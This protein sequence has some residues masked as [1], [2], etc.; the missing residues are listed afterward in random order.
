[1]SLSFRRSQL[2]CRLCGAGCYPAVPMASVPPGE[3]PAYSLRYGAPGPDSAE[4]IKRKSNKLFDFSA[5][6]E[7][8]SEHWAFV[9]STQT[10]LN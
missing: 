10:N 7:K 4:P 8:L 9:P 6:G 1:M 3:S 2:S 5:Q